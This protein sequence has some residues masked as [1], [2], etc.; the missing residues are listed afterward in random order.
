MS[1][2][3]SNSICAPRNSVEPRELSIDFLWKFVVIKFDL[4]FKLSL[5]SLI[6]RTSFY[7]RT[8]TLTKL[9]LQREFYDVLWVPRKNVSSIERYVCIKIAK[10]IRGDVQLPRREMEGSRD[11]FYR[12]NRGN[13]YR[14]S[15]QQVFL[16]GGSN[17]RGVLL[18]SNASWNWTNCSEFFSDYYNDRG[19]RTAERN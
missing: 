8:V 16:A 10:N 13:F 11:P 19:V 12:P 9:R 18:A 1:W 5:F 14:S 17:L 6:S 4:T 7:L 3:L 2:K 15:R